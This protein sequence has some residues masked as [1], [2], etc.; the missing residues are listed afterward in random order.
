MKV[1]LVRGRAIDPAVNKVAKTLSENIYDVKLLICDRQNTLSAKD[2]EGYTT[3]KFG[4]KA[5]YDKLTVIFTFQFG[6]YKSSSFC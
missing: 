6:G 1:T 4:F 2:G 3:C 5:P